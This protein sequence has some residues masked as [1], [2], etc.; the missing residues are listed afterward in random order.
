DSDD[1]IFKGEPNG[2][3]LKNFEESEGD[4]EIDV[5]PD[6]M[7]EEE[8]HKTNGGEAS[9][10][11][12]K[13][14][15]E[16]PFNI[17]DLLNK[18]KEDNKNDSNAADSLK[19]PPSFIPREYV[20]VGEEQSN[21]RNGSVRESGKGIWSIHEEEED[22]KAMKSHSKKKIKG[23]CHGISRFGSWPDLGLCKVT[24]CTG[25]KIQEGPLNYMILMWD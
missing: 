1:G 24:N 20:E 5:V 14:R 22:S 9:V 11:R 25:P 21:Q 23:R 16:D 6:T 17:Y 8:S 12:N 19:Y 4:S 13:M 18:E 2:E 15:S 10:G 3:I 7:F